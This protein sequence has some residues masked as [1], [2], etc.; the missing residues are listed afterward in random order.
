MEHSGMTERLD[1]TGEVFGPAAS[2]VPGQ[3]ANCFPAVKAI[4]VAT[5]CSYEA[6]LGR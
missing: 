1:V 6:T 3:A 2:I 5:L 4:L